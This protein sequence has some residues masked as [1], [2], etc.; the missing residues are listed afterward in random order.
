MEIDRRTLLASSVVFTVAGCVPARPAKPAVMPN[1]ELAELERKSGGR[2]GAFIQDTA[3]GKMT[4]HRVDERFAMCSS[5]KL[6]L[7]ACILQMAEQGK[8]KLDDFL[9]YTKA[10]LMHVSPVTTENLPKGGMTVEALARA[11]QV[12]SDNAAANILLRHI[13]GPARLTAFWQS[14]GDNVSRLDNEEPALNLV[15]PGAFHDTTSPQAMA[16]SL[17]KIFTG[18]V[19]VDEARERLIAWMV[20]TET[21]LKR[22]RAG[23][24]K[25]WRAGDK[26]G[27]VTEEKFGNKYIDLAIFWPPARPPV[28]VTSFYETGN[29]FDDIRDRDQAVLAEV[30]RIA[31]ATVVEWHGG[32]D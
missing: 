6:S 28:I 12:T 30:G 1:S 10:D 11:T 2:L 15:A 22:I 18:D 19:L 4:G 14:L 21:G 32:L 26:T 16:Y 9:T 17:T 24:P 23:L 5:F 29:Y 8:V 25:S 20:N 3:S 7:G 27:T 31:A 13:G